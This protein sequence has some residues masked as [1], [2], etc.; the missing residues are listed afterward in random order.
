MIDR[1]LIRHDVVQA[2]GESSGLIKSARHIQ[3]ASVIITCL[4]VIARCPQLA[5]VEQGLPLRGS[6]AHCTHQWTTQRDGSQ[7]LARILVEESHWAKWERLGL[8]LRSR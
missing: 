1:G 4:G 5:K 2:M 6:I 3:S 8:G 7:G